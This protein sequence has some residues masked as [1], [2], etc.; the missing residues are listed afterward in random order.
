MRRSAVP[1]RLFPYQA[2]PV[3]NDP[4]T[5]PGIED[6][7]AAGNVIRSAIA[8]ADGPLPPPFLIEFLLSDWRRFLVFVHFDHGADSAQWQSA[9]RTTRTLL[10]SLL[11]LENAEAKVTLL[12][13]LPGLLN[14]L[15]AGMARAGTPD[16]ARDQLLD[17]LRAAHVAVIEAPPPPAPR[18][19]IDLSQTVTV[20]LLDPRHQIGRA[21]V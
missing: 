20:N 6:V 8:E 15:R 7:R 18:E 13:T 16:A 5:Q 1:R 14:E 9:E 3:S 19:T 21:H 4:L 2:S 10:L 11:P 17:E 12:Q